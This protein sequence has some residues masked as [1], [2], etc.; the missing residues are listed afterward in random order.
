MPA[1]F[2]SEIR[3]DA[4]QVASVDVTE[5]VVL[6]ERAVE[7]PDGSLG[8]PQPGMLYTQVITPGYQVIVSAGDLELDYRLDRR[9]GFRVC[10]TPAVPDVRDPSTTIPGSSS[11]DS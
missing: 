8:C 3:A 4:A 11:T 7:W 5:V 1:G 10:E 2:V 6:E 9:G